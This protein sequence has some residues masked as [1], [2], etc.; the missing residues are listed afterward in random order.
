MP[1]PTNGELSIMLENI[2]EKVDAIIEQTTRT[3]GRVTTLETAKN[4]IFGGLL[5][6]NVI[7]LPSALILL[8]KYVNK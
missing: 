6:T 2:H 3:N 7:I 8:S 4:M 5:I 1:D